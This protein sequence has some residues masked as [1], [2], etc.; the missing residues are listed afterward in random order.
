MF[1][2]ASKM[3]LRFRTNQGIIHTEDLWDLT[4]VQLDSLWSGLNKEVK[5]LQEES[6]LAAPSAKDAAVTLRADIVKHIFDTKKAEQD[7]AKL[8]R[9]KQKRKEQLLEIL[10]DK[11]NEALRS[12]SREELLKELNDLD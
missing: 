11:E 4:L 5:A 12:K 10:G 9:D 1:E 6:L 8:L 3:K 7:E 2:K